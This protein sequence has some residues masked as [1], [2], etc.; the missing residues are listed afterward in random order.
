MLDRY[1]DAIVGTLKLATKASPF[2][3]AGLVA[4]VKSLTDRLATAP[5]QDKAGS[6]MSRKVQRP[7]IDSLWSTLEGRFTKFVAGEGEPTAQI[8]I[9][10]AAESTR[11]VNPQ[12]GPFSHYSTISPAATSGTLS[13]VPSSSDLAQQPPSRPTSASHYPMQTSSGPPPVKRAPYKTH[14]ARSS[15]LGFTAG[16]NY[17]PT[18]APSW[19]DSTPKSTSHEFPS[20]SA[21]E[22]D[23]PAHGTPDDSFSAAAPNS[24]DWW[25]SEQEGADSTAS[26][27][28]LR[29]PAF[30]PLSESFAEDDSG[31]ISPMAA[32]TPSASPSPSVSAYPY[33]Q[34]TPHKR[35]ST[36]DE[37]DDLGLGNSKSRQSAFESIEENGGEGED[38]SSGQSDVKP[39]EEQTMLEK[40][41]KLPW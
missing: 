6:W 9:A 12:V 16:Y 10:K 2:Y 34:Q 39:A 13:R 30:T 8:L 4:Q 11:P 27:S 3:N 28:S 29:A 40:P 37:L 38:G 33:N 22:Y 21:Y 35:T 31:F 18:V 5:G 20:S 17:D 26:T 24:G 36:R 19:E 25:G 32:Y 23:S 14:H 1:T 7:T 15:S 41:G